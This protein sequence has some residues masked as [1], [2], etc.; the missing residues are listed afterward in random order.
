MGSIPVGGSILLR[1]YG[2]MHG[3]CPLR[4]AFES[5]EKDHPR[6]FQ[7]Q[8]NRTEIPD[9]ESSNL[10]SG[11]NPLLAQRQTHWRQKPGI[12]VRIRER[13]PSPC[14]PTRQRHAP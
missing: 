10:S 8:R 7:W 11:T 13:G 1:C 9:S 2:G 6:V 4:S 12:A 14:S 5:L 3:S